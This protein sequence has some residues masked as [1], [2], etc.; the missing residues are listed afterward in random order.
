VPCPCTLGTQATSGMPLYDQP[1]G[2]G[3]KV[4]PGVFVL[5]F[6]L[7]RD[8]RSARRAAY[9]FMA[10]VACGA[11]VAPQDSL[12]IGVVASSESLTS[13]GSVCRWQESVAH[14]PADA[15][16][17]EPVAVEGDGARRVRS[18]L[19]ARGCSGAPP[20]SDL[21]RSGRPDRDRHRWPSGLSAVVDPSPGLV[22]AGNHGPGLAEAT[23]ERLAALLAPVICRAK[24]VLC[25]LSARSRAGRTVSGRQ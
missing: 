10:T 13:A 2:V 22:R 8:W 9:G 12:R 19:G 6:A 3:I 1:A 4:V 21:R 15:T 20:A 5:Y 24:Y 11:I 14:R 23:G 17:T 7:Q 18:C 16:L 25:L